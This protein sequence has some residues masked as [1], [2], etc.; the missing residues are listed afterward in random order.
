MRHWK[1]FLIL[2][3]VLAVITGLFL[4]SSMNMMSIPGFGRGM[5]M[6]GMPEP[7]VLTKETNL[8]TGGGMAADVVVGEAQR[9]FIA[10]VEPGTSLPPYYYGD[11]A[12]D[13]ENRVYEK[14]AYQSAVVDNVDAYTKQLEEYVLSIDGRVLSSSISQQREFQVGY[15]MA[16]VPEPKFQESVNRIAEGVKKVVSKDINSQDITGS[17]TNT[18]EQIQRIQDQIAEAQIRLEEAETDAERRRIELEIQRLERSLQSAQNQADSVEQRV[19]YATIQV[20]VAD[21]ERY[22]NP[23]VRPSLWEQFKSAWRSLADIGYLLGFIAIWTVVYAII[24][25]PV[26]LVGKVVWAKVVRSQKAVEQ[27]E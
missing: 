3:L 16:K 8:G 24:W 15:I 13:V 2:P 5:M 10:P 1:Q 21:S 17:Y 18:Q 6:N 11:D 9:S 25:V 27:E 14:Y 22:F 23:D 20:S 19:T 4:A 12:L 7:E 26:F